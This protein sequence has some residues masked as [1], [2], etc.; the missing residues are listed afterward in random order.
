[1]SLIFLILIISLVIF[2]HELGHF[3]MAKLCGVT[4]H[5]FAIGMGPKLF[6][7][8][9]GDTLY[10]LRLIPIGGF[11]RMEG[12]GLEEEAEEEEASEEAVRTVDAEGLYVE[13][14]ENAPSEGE[15]AVVSFA[16]K[17]PW[18]RLGILLA[19]V[20]NNFVFGFIL[21]LIYFLILGS[22]TTTIDK[23][24]EGMPAYEAGLAAGDR[25][26]EVEGRQIDEWSDVNRSIQQSGKTRVA[27][28]VQRGSER[29]SLDV[30]TV[31]AEDGRLIIG[32]Q[33][34][35]SHNFGNSIKNAW[36]LFGMIFTG[37]FDFF[38]NLF[39]PDVVKEVVGPIGLYKVVDEVRMSG[40]VQLIFL[41]GY[42][43]IN[44]GIINL[45]PIPAFDGGRAL[46]VVAELITGK[47]M[48]RKLEATLVG[49]GFALIMVLMVFVFYN[50]IVGLFK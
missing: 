21:L 40:L 41:M 47:P 10:A 16:D 14:G 8:K 24:V 2:V 1:M 30:D 4:V 11:V 15:G 12:E 44:I 23:V 18:A 27:I 38:R 22:A 26:L 17:S 13:E 36:A 3:T 25:I 9:K 33:S 39:N 20:F 5:E 34:R 35:L 29:L 28:V 31:K 19:G 7:K 46:F 50:D 6:S 43:S 45:F 48:N 49:I 32:I 37:I 42:L